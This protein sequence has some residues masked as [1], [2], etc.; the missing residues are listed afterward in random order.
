[1]TSSLSL[2]Q[3]RIAQ[4]VGEALQGEEYH[5]AF[6]GV[7]S[8]M[9]MAIVDGAP[10]REQALI[11]ARQFGDYLYGTVEAGLD[12]QLTIVGGVRQ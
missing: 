6:V 7:V 4:A 2:T 9:A 12:R 5:N 3:I 8:A 10:D 1:M 11:A